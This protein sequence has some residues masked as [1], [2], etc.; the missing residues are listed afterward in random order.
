MN[1]SGSENASSSSLT[2][3]KYDSSKAK[4][5]QNIS[6]L[7]SI[8]SEYK[9]EFT[10]ISMMTAMSSAGSIY[11]IFMKGNNNDASVCA[12]LQDLS[13]ALDITDP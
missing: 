12:F 5:K 9:I 11:F 13:D 4:L 8:E 1:C 2:L 3:K 10:S 7:N 6:T